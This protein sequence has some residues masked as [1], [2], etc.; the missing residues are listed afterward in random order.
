MR[1]YICFLLLLCCAVCQGENRPVNLIFDTDMAPD[2]D[3]VG[4]LAMLHAMA[5]LGEVNILATVSSNKC[6]TAVPCI[7]VEVR[8]AGNYFDIERGTMTVMDD[9]SNRWEK[10]T[11]GMHA[12]LLFKMPKEQLTGII[13][14]MMMHKPLSQSKQ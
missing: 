11:E 6:E 7:L 8:G 10:C 13:E 9:G 3:D 12:R 5:D 1:K 14:D 2:Y 4:A